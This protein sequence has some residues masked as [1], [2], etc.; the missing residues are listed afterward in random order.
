MVGNSRLQYHKTGRNTSISCDSN[1][2]IHVAV[3]G[4]LRQGLVRRLHR[5]AL[6]DITDILLAEMIL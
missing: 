1:H 6:N 4:R 3:V 2:V 5:Y